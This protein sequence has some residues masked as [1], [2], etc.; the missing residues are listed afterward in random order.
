[1]G[2]ALAGRGSWALFS[3]SFVTVL[4]EGIE[5][6]L[7][8]TTSLLLTSAFATAVGGLLGLASAVLVG[9]LVF[10]ATVRVEL[11]KLF[12]VTAVL[13]VLFAAGLVAHGIH[14]LQEAALLP[15]TYEHLWNTGRLLNEDS[16]LGQILTSLFGYNAD[17]SLLEVASYVLYL[18][19][20]GWA[21]LRP[22]RKELQPAPAG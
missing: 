14:E 19:G 20:A 7:L 12:R 17:P 2:V 22:G 8:L 13:L 15:V 5:L 4:R 3:L 1:V 10:S 11:A 18:A 21:L 16:W 6:A 9:W